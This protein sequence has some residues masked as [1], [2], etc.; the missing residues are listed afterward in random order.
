MKKTGSLDE[1]IAL[2]IPPVSCVIVGEMGCLRL[3]GRGIKPLLEACHTKQAYFSNAF[4][5][6]K[7]IGK[8]AAGILAY[9][10]VRQVYGEL[11]SEPAKQLLERYHIPVQYK[12][13]VPMIQNRAGTG[14]CPMEN[15]VKSLNSAKEIF[16]VLDSFIKE[17]MTQ[18]RG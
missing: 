17:I 6:D 10:G 14:M 7:I 3:E 11:M 12:N 5:A 4:V 2:L 13:L 16:C 8:A 9:M 15:K 18:N 1:V